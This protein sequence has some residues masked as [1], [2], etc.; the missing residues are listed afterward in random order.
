MK[1]VG[2]EIQ[3]LVQLREQAQ[4]LVR[5]T[6]LIADRAPHHRVVLLLD[7][8]TVVLAIRTRAR[9]GDLLF[10]TVGKERLI[11]ELRAVVTINAQQRKGQFGSDLLQS[12]EAPH[13]RFVLQRHAHGPARGHVRGIEREG[14]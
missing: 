5:V 7:K 9:E 11:D 3:R 12:G 6:A 1:E 2:V 10:L 14:M 13:L 4:L 8:T